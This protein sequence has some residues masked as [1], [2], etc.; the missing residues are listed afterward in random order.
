MT[1]GEFSPAARAAILEAT[2]QRCAGCDG[3][4]SLNTQHRRARGMGGTDRAELGE[5]CNGVALCGSG[6]TGCHGW[7]EHQPRHAAILGWRLN[8]GDDA[9]TTPFYTVHGWRRWTLDGP[10]SDPASWLVEH[11]DPDTLPSVYSDRMAAVTAH[12]RARF[13]NAPR[14]TTST[15]N[16]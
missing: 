5:P 7:A 2:N 1:G 3:T 15:T 11:A 10:R 12:R 14:K 13:G 16:H 8:P 9:L 4:W 6:T